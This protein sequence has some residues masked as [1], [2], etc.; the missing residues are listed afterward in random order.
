MT[1]RNSPI[2]SLSEWLQPISEGTCPDEIIR[3]ISWI[4]DFVA[5]PH[6]DI[7]RPGPVCPIVPQAL[8]GNSIFLTYC[9][10]LPDSTELYKIA[11]ELRSPFLQLSTLFPNQIAIALLLLF[12]FRAPAEFLT[13]LEGVQQELKV[14]FMEEATLLGKF[15]P[16]L[17]TTALHNSKF[18]PSQSP[19]PMLAV[20]YLVESDI[21]FIATSA[22]PA[23][24]KIQCMKRYLEVMRENISIEARHNIEREIAALTAKMI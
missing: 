5:K 7:G 6:P 13:K 18:R 16:S 8:R 21:R 4:T 17:R 11:A 3:T 10:G 20:R 19:A 14:W 1:F 2:R 15:H 22:S 9:D 24:V 23:Q 12:P